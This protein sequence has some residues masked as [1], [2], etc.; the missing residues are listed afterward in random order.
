MR[1]T[2][3]LL[4]ALFLGSFM[5]SPPVAGQQPSALRIAVVPYLTPSVLL[6]LFQP[7]RNHLERE[8]KQ[9]VEL[10]TAPDIRTH[11]KRIQRPEYDAVITSAHF[12]RLAQL[13]GG[14]IPVAGFDSPLKAIVSVNKDS[15]IQSLEDL[16]GRTIAVNDRLVLV[17]I[18]ALQDIQARGVKPEEMRLAPAVTQNS[19][20]LS[21]A[22]GDVDAAITAQF[23]LNQI[24]EQ[25]RQGIRTIYTTDTLPNVKFLAGYRLSRDLRDRMQAALLAFGDTPDGARFFANSGFTAIGRVSETQM[26]LLDR[27]IPETRRLLASEP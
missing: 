22:S 10:Y 25:Q 9:P 24:P 5:F 20:L 12:S 7:I 1:H 13:D 19:S 15:A 27:Y 26:K 8:L 23:T 2:A 21:V 6:A 11:V 17:S 16:K 3:T 4:L 18:V 14:Y